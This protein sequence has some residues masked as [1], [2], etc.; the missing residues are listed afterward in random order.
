MC[1]FDDEDEMQR[2][3][4]EHESRLSRANCGS[5]FGESPTP[6]AAS[7]G[8]LCGSD[9]AHPSSCD[10]TPP[11][12]LKCSSSHRATRHPPTEL[13]RDAARHSNDE[14][15]DSDSDG[16]AEEGDV[17]VATPAGGDMRFATFEAAAMSSKVPKGSTIHLPNGLHRWP[18]GDL[19]VSVRGEGPDTV[20]YGNE[21]S[22][23]FFYLRAN[24]IRIRDLTLQGQSTGRA[25]IYA[26]RMEGVDIVGVTFR[27]PYNH[28]IQAVEAEDILLE[29]CVC[30]DA[31][32]SA[33]QV[34]NSSNNITVT[35]CCFFDTCS[36]PVISVFNSTNVSVQR[37]KLFC[38]NTGTFYIH[39][40]N[41]YV[42]QDE[43]TVDFSGN[44]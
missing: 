26:D 34:S 39:T 44:A 30:H 21:G 37:C 3:L 41:A 28:C 36:T 7:G 5:R 1:D 4:D 17:R 14:S 10:A 42:A 6:A 15:W 18:G 22:G 25:H 27:G 16:P 2:I 33:M 20:L 12:P 43:N 35:D 11:P 13:L 32:Q 19:S 8:S 29:D 31:V 40:N 38:R 23:Y 24:S 9:A